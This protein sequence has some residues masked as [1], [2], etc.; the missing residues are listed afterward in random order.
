MSNSI[1][2]LDMSCIKLI[3]YIVV[4]FPKN[5]KLQKEE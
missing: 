4:K 3:E 1:L 5:N 2:D